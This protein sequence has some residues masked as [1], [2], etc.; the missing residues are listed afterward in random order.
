MTAIGAFNSSLISV[1]LCS[2]SNFA[3]IALAPGCE[4]EIALCAAATIKDFSCSG[5]A[6]L[7][8]TP[9]LRRGLI[10]YW[11]PL[12]EFSIEI[13]VTRACLAPRC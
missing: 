9:L 7:M 1:A 13:R 12:A 6:R 5:I 2:P 11:P 8:C 3:I 4:I 10:S